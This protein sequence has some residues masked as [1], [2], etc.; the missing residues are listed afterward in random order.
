MRNFL[1]PAGSNRIMLNGKLV[2]KF[3]KQYELLLNLPPQARAIGSSDL[4]AVA[5]AK[6]EAEQKAISEKWWNWGILTRTNCFGSLR[7]GEGL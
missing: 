6:V 2:M 3:Q 7:S 5:L 1:K 4:S